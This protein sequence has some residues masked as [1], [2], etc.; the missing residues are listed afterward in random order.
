[1]SEL[2]ARVGDQLHLRVQ[3]E[4]GASD[5]FIRA[6]AFDESHSALPG[7]PYLMTHRQFGNYTY[8]DPALTFP[9]VNEVYVQ[10]VVFNDA[11]FTEVDDF[12]G[13]SFSVW[14]KS[15]E[16]D[17]AVEEIRTQV[18]QILNLVAGLSSSAD[19]YA[20]IDPTD[21]IEGFV[22]I[23]ELTG[24]VQE[25]ELIGFIRSQEEELVAL[26]QSDVQLVGVIVE[27]PN[28]V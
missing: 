26:I 11:A 15:Y 20:V 12:H 24:T 10:Y 21:H 19:L 4:D 27:E 3:L 9:D 22:I 23:D 17:I 16:I 6:Y 13:I 5:K 8:S 2:L 7:S 18:N 14:R 1:M 28:N 25:N